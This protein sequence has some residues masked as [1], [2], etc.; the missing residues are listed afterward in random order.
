MGPTVL[1]LG[2]TYYFES[3]LLIGFMLVKDKIAV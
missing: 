2:N 1:T 3:R